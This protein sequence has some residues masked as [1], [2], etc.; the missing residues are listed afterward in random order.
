MT[1][2]SSND[3][4]DLGGARLKPFADYSNEAPHYNANMVM[5]DVPLMQPVGFVW[6]SKP[7]Y[8]V[9]AGRIKV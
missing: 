8:R 2:K 6:L 4:W 9:K 5:D 7:R 3:D 1:S